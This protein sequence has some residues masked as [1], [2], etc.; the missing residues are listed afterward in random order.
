MRMVWRFLFRSQS[1]G[2]LPYLTIF[3]FL[4]ISIG[5]ATLIIVLS[6]MNGFSTT[7]QEQLVGVYSPIRVYSLHPGE[8]ELEELE[9]KLEGEEI[10]EIVGVVEG[11]VLFQS[12]RANYS[13]GRI[14]AYTS[15][16]EG[17]LPVEKPS[18]SGIYLGRELAR[19]LFVQRGEEL[20]V[21][22][23]DAQRTPFG[24]LPAAETL[25]VAGDL[26]TGFQDV[27]AALGLVS[28]EEARQL[29]DLA[30]GRVSHAELWIEDRFRADDVKQ[31]L[32]DKLAD[33][34]NMVTWMEANPALF[35]ALR[36][37]RTVT[38]I[39][40][41]LIVIVAAIN[42]LSMLVLSILQRRRQIAMMMSMGAS[43][44]TVLSLFL[45]AGMLITVIG[46]AAGFGFGLSGCWLLDNVFV[47]ELPP[48][49]PMA[50]L[51]VQVETFHL[52][53]IGAVTLILGFLSSFYPAWAAA[54]ID[55]A[56]VLRY[57]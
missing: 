50:H 39:V 54:K 55:P 43:P 48:V 41:A 25:Q 49:Y 53:A 5:V 23:P 57:G 6:V 24:L 27:D 35:E 32:R 44:G 8:I 1:V 47:I 12:G 16:R 17:R 52:V 31:E 30:E 20:T 13:G 11:D 10:E 51:P 18:E 19:E 33:N 38:F 22:R 34:Y 29:F 2:V 36:L 3:A 4:S 26:R 40:L 46:L 15:W 21:I 9:E 42:I 45:A 37:E 28:I 14:I 56:E 7:L